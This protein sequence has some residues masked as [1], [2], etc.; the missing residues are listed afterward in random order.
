MITYTRRLDD[1][2]GNLASGQGETS[3]KHMERKPSTG[4]HRP[5]T[6]PRQNAKILPGFGRKKNHR[7]PSRNSF[8]SHSLARHCRR[9]DGRFSFRAHRPGPTTFRRVVEKFPRSFFRVTHTVRVRV[10]RPSPVVNSFEF[11]RL[12]PTFDKTVR[13]F[14]VATDKGHIILTVRNGAVCSSFRRPA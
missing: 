3:G 12:F 7:F 10:A 4:S 11:P 9:V 2:R 6:R 13:R 1:G 5:S 8:N 14:V